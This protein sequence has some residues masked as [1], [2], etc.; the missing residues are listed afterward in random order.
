MATDTDYIDVDML[1]MAVEPVGTYSTPQDNTL[2]QLAISSA[3]ELTFEWCGRHFYRTELA[4]TRHYEA[5]TGEWMCVDDFHD[6][7]GLVLK[8]DNDF[9]GVFETTWT[10]GTDFVAWP[11]TRLN[12]RPYTK[13]YA[14]GAKRFPVGVRRPGAEVLTR[15][16]WGANP[17]PV[18]QGNLLLSVLF[19][20]LKDIVTADDYDINSAYVAATMLKPYACKGGT[21]HEED[22]MTAAQQKFGKATL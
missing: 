12:G 18:V 21:L 19:Y 17:K 22:P 15:W 6:T 9:D 14:V 13:L 20:K 8:T 7:T 16:G 2:Y 3:A 11:Y 1:K 5:E 4:E 10:L